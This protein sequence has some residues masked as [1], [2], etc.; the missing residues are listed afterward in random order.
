MTQCS[1][2]SYFFLSIGLANIYKILF[3]GQIAGAIIEQ[4]RCRALVYKNP[5]PRLRNMSV[6]EIEF[7][8]EYI[9]LSPWAAL[10]FD[11]FKIISC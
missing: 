3:N 9:H 5:K 6:W 1:P 7:F 11:K 8:N 2:H 10:I 4:A